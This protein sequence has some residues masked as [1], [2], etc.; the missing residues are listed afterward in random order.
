MARSLINCFG[1]EMNFYKVYSDSPNTGLAYSLTSSPAPPQGTYWIQC[2]NP[3]QAQSIGQFNEIISNY[4]VYWLC[5]RG[6]RIE[7]TITTGDTFPV[8][9]FKTRLP[10]DVGALHIQA[11]G[12]SDGTYKL[13]MTETAG[14]EQQS[15]TPVQL[16]RFVGK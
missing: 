16:M 14:G 13:A 9:W 15:L 12:Q 7:G 8:M 6:Y 3:T 5:I 1:P 4:Q 2:I 11:I 10:N